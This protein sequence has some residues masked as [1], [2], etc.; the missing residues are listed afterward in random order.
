MQRL[1]ATTCGEAGE[2]SATARDLAGVDLGSLGFPA[3]G[4]NRFGILGTVLL[5]LVSTMSAT[6]RD[7][8]RTTKEGAINGSQEEGREESHEEGYE[9]GR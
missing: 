4:S 3:V 9:E 2:V 8:R 1:G 6:Q 5:D 7:R